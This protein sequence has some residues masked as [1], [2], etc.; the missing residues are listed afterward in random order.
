[1]NE[2][3]WNNESWGSEYPPENFEEIIHAANREIDDFIERS[4]LD[5][6]NSDDAVVICEFSERLWAF[7]CE[8][9]K[10]PDS[11]EIIQQYINGFIADCEAR[12]E[13]DD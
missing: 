3:Y 7:Y 8:Y 1:M 12:K 9:D 4:E 11:P 5:P 13:R 6:E 2:F 10:L